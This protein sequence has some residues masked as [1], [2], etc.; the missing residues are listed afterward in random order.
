MRATARPGRQTVRSA[1]RAAVSAGI[2]ASSGETT[3]AQAGLRTR[4]A[5]RSPSRRDVRQ[6]H[7]RA[8]LEGLTVAGAVAELA[9]IA[10]G[11]TAFPFH[12]P[13]KGFAAD[14]CG[15]D[16]TANGRHFLIHVGQLEYSS[17][18]KA[19]FTMADREAP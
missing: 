7:E 19:R 13:R 8:A 6:W 18:V 11:G 9:S 16:S 4:R 15:T 5:N 10:G 2:A 14:T 1:T 17:H 3:G 12:P